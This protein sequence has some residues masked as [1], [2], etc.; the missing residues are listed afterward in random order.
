MTKTEAIRRL[1]RN[2]LFFAEDADLVDNVFPVGLRF[3]ER[4]PVQRLTFAPDSRVWDMI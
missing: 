2:I 4:V 1:M 3:V